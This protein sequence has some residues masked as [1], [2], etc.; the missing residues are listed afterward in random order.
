MHGR[1]F[2]TDNAPL[3]EKALAGCLE[4][5]L[6][7]QDWLSMLNERVFFWPD[8]RGPR[9]LA[10]ARLNRERERII[11][12]LDTLRLV[13]QHFEKV[14]LTAINTGAT[15]MRPAPR[16][17]SSFV[18]LARHSYKEF[19]NLRR[20]NGPLKEVVVVG[21]VPDINDF[22]INVLSPNS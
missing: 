22:L 17:L 20:K 12:V 21:G 18:P 8:E 10:K 3:S 14:E 15:I 1:A 5:G 9:E 4:D 2:L 16:G 11:L 7:P 6:S 19:R 13:R